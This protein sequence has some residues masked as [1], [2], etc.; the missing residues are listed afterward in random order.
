MFSLSLILLFSSIIYSQNV[1]YF[2]GENAMGYLNEQCEI[3]P[4]YPGSIGHANAIKLYKEHFKEYS[5][6]VILF[7][8]YVIH[9]HSLDSIKLTNIFSRFKPELN[10]RLLLMAHFDTREFADKDLNKDNHDK[11]ILGANDG[12]SGVAILM[13]IAKFLNQNPLLNLGVDILLTDGEDMGKPGD[14]DSWALGAK[15]FSK[16]IPSPLPFAAICVDMVGDAE[17]TLPIERHSY[18]QAP[19]L[20]LDVWGLAQELGYSQFKMDLGRAIIDDHSVFYQQTKIPAID[21]IDFDYPNSTLN[22]WHTLQ[23]TPDKCSAES[24]EAVGTVL[25]NYLYRLDL[26]ID[27]K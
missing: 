20:V 2:D 4:R 7:S 8:D 25:V 22:Y 16:K 23:D 19:Q 15:I 13:E 18:M 5:D 3:G 27:E 11:P 21:I 24:L 6:D 17:L 26:G 12:A 14:V 1:L 9:P 10:N